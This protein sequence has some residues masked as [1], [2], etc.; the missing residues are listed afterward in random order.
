AIGFLIFG[1][2]S[3]R[4]GQR[5][6]MVSGM[7]GLAVAT[8]GVCVSPNVVVFLLFRAAQGLAAATFAPGALVWVA[9]KAPE[10]RRGVALSILT[11]GLLGAGLAG[12]LYGTATLE[13]MPWQWMFLTASIPYLLFA[14]L[15][16]TM[17]GASGIIKSA[18]LGTVY[19]PIVR[20]LTQWPTAS[21]FM[22]AL[23]VFGS[24]V[25]MYA[26]LNDRLTSAEHFTAVGLLAVEGIG[27]LGLLAAPTLHWLARTPV[28]PRTQTL[29]GFSVAAAGIMVEQ[30][31]A[32]WLVPVAGSV[33][34]VAGI[35]LVVPGLVGLLAHHAPR[36]R[37]A[38][39]GFNTFLLFVGA[40]IVPLVIGHFSYHSSMAI[41]AAALLVAAGMIAAGVP[42]SVDSA[43]SHALA[44]K[45]WPSSSP[46][47]ALQQKSGVEGDHSGI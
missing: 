5:Q 39:V 10:E 27:C 15:L 38:A 42:R 37:A 25:G 35:S 2:L 22:A 3:D 28:S 12:Q 26:V 29:F 14:L 47:P 32:N 20:L 24:F 33:G 18:P 13:F 16:H 4:Y 41:L 9:E 40:A 43:Y 17:L 23:A 1:P 44:A 8:A 30:I 11:T 7:T 19:R 46:Q 36:E 45:H 34:Y 21:V 31:D 6:V